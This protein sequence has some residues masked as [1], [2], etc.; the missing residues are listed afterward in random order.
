MRPAAILTTIGDTPLIELTRIVPKGAAR[1]FLK[2]EAQNP[3][4]SM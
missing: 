4:G 1:I 3:T 2:I